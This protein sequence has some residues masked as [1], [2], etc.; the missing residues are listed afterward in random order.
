M[1]KTIT[2]M[3]TVLIS[4]ILLEVVRA[5]PEQ[6]T[7][8][9]RFT[10]STDQNTAYFVCN[11]NEWRVNWTYTPNPEYP[12]AAGFA[13][14]I[15]DNVSLTIDS[16]YQSGNETTFG[17]TYLHNKAGT[18]Y[19]TIGVANLVDYT[20]IIEQDLDSIPE[21]PIGLLFAMLTIALVPL[22]VLK[23]RARLRAA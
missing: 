8:V 1:R 17:L 23:H 13:C 5:S 2:I 16:I 10:G 12:T 15:K 7:E 3:L 14:T 18:F 9:T 4:L 22:A 6:W 11:H 21:Y 20:I 19:L